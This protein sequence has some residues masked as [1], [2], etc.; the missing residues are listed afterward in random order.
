MLLDTETHKVPD[1]VSSVSNK[2]KDF[3]P[4]NPNLDVESAIKR[5]NR[6]NKL[7]EKI[8]DKPFSY[9]DKFYHI[10]GSHRD[11]SK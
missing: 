11:R 8:K 7:Y 9:Y 1:I 4:W 2:M 5:I 6:M 10:H 3:F